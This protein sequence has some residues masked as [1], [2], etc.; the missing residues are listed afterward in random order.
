MTVAYVDTNVIVRHL[1]GDAPDQARAATELLM[2]PR[3]LVLTPFIFIEIAH[4]L[5]SYYGLSRDAITDRLDAVI[6]LPAIAGDLDLLSAALDIHACR[7]VS[8]PDALL[9]AE[10]KQSGITEIV[11]FDRGFDRIAGVTRI[12]P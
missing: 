3:R 6:R 2:Q 10:A 5:R 12:T 1:V 4:V 11:S 7:G 8:M 9:A